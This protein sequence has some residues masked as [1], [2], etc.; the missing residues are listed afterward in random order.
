[1]STTRSLIIF[2]FILHLILAERER[3][4]D[5]KGLIKRRVVSVGRAVISTLQQGVE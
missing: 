2:L 4:R 5:E 3:E 1:M